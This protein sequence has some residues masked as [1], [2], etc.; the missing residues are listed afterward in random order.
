ML[1]IPFNPTFCDVFSSSV[2]VTLSKTTQLFTSFNRRSEAKNKYTVAR[3]ID[4]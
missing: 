4:V 2:A 3:E 1:H